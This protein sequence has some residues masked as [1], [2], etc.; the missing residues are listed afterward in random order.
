MVELGCDL[1]QILQ[2]GEWVSPAF[3]RYLDSVKFEKDAVVQAHLEES[4]GGDDELCGW[5]Q[6]LFRSKW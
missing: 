4:H 5:A 2:A 6:W 1:P 3:L